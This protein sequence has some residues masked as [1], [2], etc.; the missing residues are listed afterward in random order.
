MMTMSWFSY[1]QYICTLTRARRIIV[2]CWIFALFYSSPWLLLSTVKYSCIQGFGMV[3]YYHNFK[4][5]ETLI[6]FYP[7]DYFV[8]VICTYVLVLIFLFARFPNVTSVFAVTQRCTSWFSSQTSPCS[9]WSRWSSP[10]CCTP[11]SPSCSC[12]PPPGHST[13][14]QWGTRPGSRSVTRSRCLP[15]TDAVMQLQ[16]NIISFYC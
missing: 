7:L 6:R 11:W 15:P 2:C 10:W 9:T 12:S 13:T 4:S 5:D 3:R 8:S 1:S 14:A 16:R